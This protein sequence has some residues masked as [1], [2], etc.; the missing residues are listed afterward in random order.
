[1]QEQETDAKVAKVAGVA[2]PQEKLLPSRRGAWSKRRMNGEKGGA[3]S[4]ATERKHAMQAQL[5]ATLQE[6]QEL[7]RVPEVAA[8]SWHGQV[9]RCIQM[10]LSFLSS[11]D[12]SKEPPGLAPERV[13][14]FAAVLRDKRKAA[15]LTQEQLA[16]SAL[17]SKRTIYGIEAGKQAPSRSTMCRLLAVPG[18]NL[19]V[20]D[21]STDVTLDPA[22]SPNCWLA[23]RYNPSE[24]MQDMV[25][26]LNGPGG[27]L[28]QTHLYLEPQSANDYMALCSTAPVF[29]G[30][31]AAAPLE[32][33]AAQTV[34]R[35]VGWGVDVAGLG[36]GDGQSEVRLVQAIA[37]G[38][39]ASA[40][41]RLYLLDVSHTMLSVAYKHARSSL[42]IPGL[43]V[44]AL[45]A[46]FHELARYDFLR[47]APA[48]RRRRVYTLLGGTMANLDNEVRFFQDLGQCAA[49]DDLCVLDLQ[50]VYAPV[51]DAE[52]IRRVDPPLAN[53]GNP[54][55]LKW[56][57]GP[58]E[59]HCH[60][61]ASI[62]LYTDL[63]THCPVP[64]SYEVDFLGR[65]RMRDGLERQ[66]L[67]WRVKRYDP[68]RLAKCL[69]GLGWECLTT[70]RYGV[71]AQKTAAVM[72]LRKR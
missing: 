1:M 34:K 19:A 28:E 33:I 9:S 13:A 57:T 36:S 39:G 46:N 65:V 52:E 41:L 10:A 4:P 38:R 12:G 31:R 6:L 29:V 42:T 54:P 56:L 24:L 11:G 58:L 32:Q 14:E 26:L 64:G 2:T 27:Q 16:Q 48:T 67:V 18:L 25:N 59:R 51:E 20:S 22:W 70:M 69:E 44:F 7:E 49:P 15:G 3:I 62:Q 35:C 43:A 47:A 60:G 37:R 17:L 55:H 50:I 53:R 23:P 40:D 8:S 45:H 71:A 61:S 72:L 63:T 30:F 21:F 5:V 68:E 66:F